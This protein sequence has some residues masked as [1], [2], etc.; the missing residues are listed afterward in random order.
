M[1]LFMSI[2]ENYDVIV[3]GSGTGGA[4]ASKFLVQRG[5]SVAMLDRQIRG[6]IHKICGDATS[7][8]HFERLAERDPDKKNKVATPREKGELLQVMKGFS[9]FTPSGNRYDIPADGD[10]WIIARDKFTARL[11]NE[12]L[13]AGVEYYDQT[14]VRNPNMEG[15]T[16]KGVNVRTKEGELKD[17][18]AKIV[19]DAS[20]MA[21]IVRRHLD[22]NKAQWDSLIR[23]YDLAT[24]FRELVTFKNYKFERPDHIEIYF[25]TDNCPGG[26]FWVFPNGESSANVGIG[27][28]PRK[29]EG[30]PKKGYEWWVNHLKHIFGGGYTVS[31]KGGWNVPLRRPMDSLVY[32]GVVL[33]GDAGSCVKATDGGGIGL[34]LISA[35]QCVNPIVRAIEEDNLTL[36]GPLWDYNVRFMRQTGAHEAPL[37][38]AKTAVTKATN[39]EL[40]IIFDKE[41]I[42]A[43]DLYNLNAGKPI[44]SGGMVSLKRLWRGRRILPFLNGIRSSMNKMETVKQLYFNYP[45]RP[46]D[47]PE[48]R[49]KIIKL[50]NDKNRAE[51][52]YTETG[53]KPSKTN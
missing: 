2:K 8:I 15:D 26:Y 36:N 51:K 24:A 40:N 42:S 52:F 30:G 31:H 27:L 4:A 7:A 3:V 17:I 14:T 22:E 49:T 47:L 37:A 53:K 48:W 21:G 18:K 44:S 45:E 10:G 12:A 38:L 1:V 6:D 20:G 9:F 33:I 41:V 28:E 16:V 32:N 5:L 29:Y 13:D 46:E 19:I 35:S 11:I 43:T 39:K 25:D 23:H 34:S 50:F